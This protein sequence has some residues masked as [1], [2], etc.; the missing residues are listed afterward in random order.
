MSVLQIKTA[1]VFEPLLQPA[2][3]K[4][5]HG[6]RGSGKSHFFGEM[7]VEECLAE[8]GTLAVCIREVQKTLAQSSKRLIEAKIR[9]MNVGPEFRVFTGD[10]VP[11]LIEPMHGIVIQSGI[12]H[13]RNPAGIQSCQVSC[14]FLGPLPVHHF[15]PRTYVEQI[16]VRQFDYLLL[17]LAH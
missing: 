4:A 13:R 17:H 8:K 2:R 16:G 7:L 1:E 15:F 3:Y 5:A 11:R 12:F 14:P 9:E 10:L 6:G